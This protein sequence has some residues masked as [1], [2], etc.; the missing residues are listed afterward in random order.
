MERLS[1]HDP[2]PRKTER[3][4]E[5]RKSTR[6]LL[7]ICL[8]TA[9]L[10]APAPASAQVPAPILRSSPTFEVSPAVAAVYD[11]YRVKPI[12]FGAGAD[13]APVAQLI[14]ILRRAPFDGFADGPQLAAAVEAAQAQVRA[15]PAAAAKADQVLSSAWVRYVKALRQPT[16][17]MIYA[18]ENLKPKKARTDEILLTTAAASSLADY[19]KDVS[20]LNPLYSQ[21]RD[22]AWADAK[23]SG[24]LTPDPRLLANL[25]RIKAVPARG[26]FVLVDSG[27]QLLTMY[28]NGHPVDSMKIIVGTNEL[29]TP[30]I[31]S[32]MYYVTYNPYWHAPDHLVR[33]TIAPTVLR[34]GMSYLKRQGYHVVDQWTT[35]PTEVDATTVDWKGAAAGD[36]HL[37][38]R[39]DPGPLNSMGRLKFP[40]SNPEGIYLH[41]TP[42][43]DL[44]AKS[45]RNLSNGCVRLEDATRLGRWLLGQEPVAPGDEPETQ[46][47]LPEGVPI[48]LTY[49]TAQVSDGRVAYLDDFYGWDSGA[50]GQVA[51]TN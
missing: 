51:S 41:D 17:G 29:P 45:R 42:S 14:E 47:R 12:W 11:T 8:G 28:D 13:S 19:L 44:F 49:L 46:V 34:Q 31:A 16:P 9:A 7:S 24:N 3:G 2:V 1:W 36:V 39:Q 21:L 38:V 48:I 32:M 23:A 18:A 26:R 4:C 35:S 27:S 50:S 10:V 37:F 30:L 22:A 6:Q 20:N 25:E 5:L 40:F 15:D 43:K 33:K